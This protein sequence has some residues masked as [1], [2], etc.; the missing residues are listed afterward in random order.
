MLRGNGRA[1]E[2]KAGDAADAPGTIDLDDLEPAALGG[3][4]QCLLL[5]GCCLIEGREPKIDGR[6]F[7]RTLPALICWKDNNWTAQ[8]ARFCW[9]LVGQFRG[10]FSVQSSD[11]HTDGV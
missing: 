8:R 4:P 9:D 2:A 6:A 3:L 7:H 1:A 11:Q 5:I 10:G